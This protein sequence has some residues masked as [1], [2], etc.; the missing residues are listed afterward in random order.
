[1]WVI[2]AVEKVNIKCFINNS[3]GDHMNEYSM[4]KSSGISVIVTVLCTIAG[5]ICAF[6]SLF[7]IPYAFGVVGVIMGIMAS[8]NG[9]KHGL[10]IIMASVIFMGIGLMFSGTIL[11]YSME[12]IYGK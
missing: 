1:L 11:Y 6:L 8:K 5:W 4:E 9:S 7:I 12:Y 2:G 3:K 10:P